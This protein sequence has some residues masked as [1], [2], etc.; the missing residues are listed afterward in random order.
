MEAIDRCRGAVFK[1]LWTHYYDLVPYAPN[2]ERK[3]REQGNAWIEDHV[4]YRTLPGENTGMHVLQEV[5]ELLGYKREDDYKFEEKKLKAFWMSPSD[6][7]GSSEKA[8]A[9][10]FI[11]EYAL[12]SLNLDDFKIEIFPA[13]KIEQVFRE[14]FA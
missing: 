1:K 2:I 9:K 13:A 12:S 5:F 6:T 3:F 14:L 4:A 10:I 11:S 8:S 7:S